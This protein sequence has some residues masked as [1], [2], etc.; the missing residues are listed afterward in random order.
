MTV[1]QPKAPDSNWADSYFQPGLLQ[2]PPYSLDLTK[3]PIKLDQNEVPWDFPAALKERVQE[4][5]RTRAWNRYPSPYTPELTEAIARYVGV[6]AT[7]VFTGPGSNY[8]ITVVLDAL[9]RRLSG[10]V[11]VARPSFALFESHCRYTGI[12]HEPWELDGDFEYDLTK[13]RDMPRGSL[14]IF[15]SPNNPT[16]SRIPAEKLGEL[17]Q[18]HPQ[19][20]FIADE[21]YF[22]FGSDNYVALLAQHANLLLLRTFSKTMGAA[23]VRLGYVVGAEA[24][25]KQ[26]VKLRLPYL[27]NHFAVEGVLAILEDPEMITFCRNNVRTLISERDRVHRALAPLAS[28]QGFKLKNTAANFLFAQWPTAERCRTF[29]DGLVAKGILVRD[30]SKGPGLQGCLRISVGSPQEN[31]ALLRAVLG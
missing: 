28:A 15:A 20:L 22:E 30:V 11:I 24:F 5:V 13:L 8:L 6:P 31:D 4:R 21:A 3:T 18:A 2:A 29:Y 16:G 7:S 23:G 14:V 26:L 17:L 9:G 19:S 25:I 10:K 12:A 27:L 1:I